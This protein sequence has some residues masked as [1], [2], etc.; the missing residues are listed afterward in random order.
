LKGER[1]RDVIERT[2]QGTRGRMKYRER[3]NEEEG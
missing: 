1:T 3:M 2:K